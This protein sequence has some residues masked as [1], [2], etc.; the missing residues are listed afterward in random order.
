[1]VVAYATREP[2]SPASSNESL[3]PDGS[4]GARF[5]RRPFV[6]GARLQD[7]Q[8]CRLP[9]VPRFSAADSTGCLARALGRLVLPR[10]FSTFSQILRCRLEVYP[11]LRLRGARTGKWEAETLWWIVDHGDEN[12]FWSLWTLASLPATIGNVK[13]R[14]LRGLQL[15]A[16]WVRKDPVRF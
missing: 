5:S 13:T 4:A 10:G 15:E 2:G 16:L 7:L 11:V 14:P 8:S 3:R 1:M 6:F 9:H 12:T